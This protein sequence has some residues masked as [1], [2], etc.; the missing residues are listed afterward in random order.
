MQSFSRAC[1]APEHLNISLNVNERF[2]ANH[3]QKYKNRLPDSGA[4][5]L[6]KWN[7]FKPACSGTSTWPALV[8]S[9]SLLQH[10]SQT[11]FQMASQGG[12]KLNAVAKFFGEKSHLSALLGLHGSPDW[13]PEHALC[14]G[15]LTAHRVVQ[16]FRVFANN[17]TTLRLVNGKP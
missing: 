15:Q 7:G 1:Y 11:A 5:H 2:D 17:R 8:A 3:Y 9:G 10:L 6:C 14:T 16:V 13:A 12:D 4:S